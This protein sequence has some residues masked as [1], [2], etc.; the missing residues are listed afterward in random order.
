M[1]LL[2]LIP[3]LA[4]GIFLFF[5]TGNLG[6]L[7][8]SGLTLAV[9]VM[10]SGQRQLD[11]KGELSF[12]DDRIFLDNRRLG[13]VP[14][15]WPTAVRNR[16]YLD[17]FGEIP[18]E[19]GSYSELSATGIGWNQSG[20]ELR[21]AP[22]EHAPHS[23]IIGPTG[24]GKTELMK[25]MV[26]SFSGEVWAIDFKGGMGFR[27]NPKVSILLT[28][29]DSLSALEH[30]QESFSSRQRL[31][32]PKDILLVVDE[33]GEVMKN[34]KFAQFIE[35]VAAKGRSLG[36]Y[37]VCANQTLSMVPRTIWVNCANR[38]SLKADMVDKTQLGM[39]GS[40]SV[41]AEGYGSAL[42]R[43]DS[44]EIELL[45]PLGFVHEKT[46]P[47]HTEAVNPLLARVDPKL[48]LVPYEGFA[49]AR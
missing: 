20:V 47:V 40:E 18:E 26:R 43:C 12:R 17:C 39:R 14:W 48:R 1:N 8:L 25:L 3:G 5:S 41:P 49:Q 35:S 7:M 16:V 31:R 22:S 27:H 42:V 38:Y 28:E 34:L 11:P 32:P 19:T 37:L 33:L 4:Y 2:F 30:L 10:I 45:F 23:I 44:A 9:W 46:A 21:F 13:M 15:L 24:S 6:L 36:V 29:E